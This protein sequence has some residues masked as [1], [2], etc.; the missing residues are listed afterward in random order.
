MVVITIIGLAAAAVVLTLPAANGGARA[1]ATR[2]A[3]HRSVFPS[4]TR[5]VSSRMATGCFPARH[6]LQGNTTV[7]MEAGRL[8][9][10]DAG[11]PEFLQHRRSV[12]GASLAMP[13]MAQRLKKANPEAFRN[14]VGRLLEVNEVTDVGFS[15]E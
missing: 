7:L 5:V 8:V 14:L 9:R 2:F 3:A 15:G 13:T 1:E 11:L 10:R 4:A 12:T 6:G